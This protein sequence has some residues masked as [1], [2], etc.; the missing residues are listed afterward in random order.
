MLEGILRQF[1]NQT[2]YDK[3]L[4]LTEDTHAANIKGTVNTNKTNTPHNIMVGDNDGDNDKI[5]KLPKKWRQ[6]NRYIINTWIY[7]PRWN[8]LKTRQINI[9]MIREEEERGK[10]Q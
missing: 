6:Q 5:T 4:T 3:N 8:I 2:Q 1:E 7:V 9:S 10:Q